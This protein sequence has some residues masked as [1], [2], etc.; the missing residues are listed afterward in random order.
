M[1]GKDSL[2]NVAL[3]ICSTLLALGLVGATGELAVRYR[4]RH[5]SEVPGSM[6]LMFYQHSRLRHALVRN[7]DY[8]GWAHID[9]QGFRGRP[10]ATEKPPDVLRIMVVGS[11]TTFDP[12]VTGD[13]AAWP[14]RLEVWLTRLSPERKYEVINAG[15]PGYR[16]IDD[17]IRLETELYQ[18]QPDLIIL[19]EGHNDL[20]SA[21]QHSGGEG[22]DEVDSSPSRPGELPVVTPWEHWL[23]SHS[24]LYVK[25]KKR[26]SVISFRSRGATVLR[27]RQT[28]SLDPIL[29]RGAQNIARDVTAFLAV[30][31]GFGVR[32]AMPDLVNVSGVGA[33]EE[34][35]PK[36][37]DEWHQAVPFVPP[38]V[39]LSGY[40]RYSAAVR[41]VAE[42]DG[43]AWIPTAS[44]GLRGRKWYASEDPIH[45]NDTGS[46][47]FGECIARALLAA[48]LTK[49]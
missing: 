27:S 32:V 31:R 47:R 37:R 44:C 35:D 15:V 21:L 49:K 39:A 42:H 41:E 23:T 14:A 8:F 7:Y 9:A 5:R 16:V 11:S 45:F 20:F 1:S 22:G 48:G 4:E 18:Y 2:A 17:L 36:T 43:S 33:T 10:V 30:A 13:A 24:L 25:I 12:Q 46:D 19:Y 34:P 29:D 3:A 28:A 38:E 40:V 26:L 6:S